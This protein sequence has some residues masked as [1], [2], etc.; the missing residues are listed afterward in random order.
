MAFETFSESCMLILVA[1]SQVTLP[2]D[3]WLP[4]RWLDKKEGTLTVTLEPTDAKSGKQIYK[5]WRNL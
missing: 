1:Q 3:G 5:V 4:C 2:A